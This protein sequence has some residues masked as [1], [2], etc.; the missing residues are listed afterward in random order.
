LN[1]LKPIQIEDGVFQIRGVG[2]KTTVVVGDGKPCMIDASGPGS[3]PMIEA[4]LNRMGLRP[5]DIDLIALTHYHPDHTGGL[6]KLVW[7]S[8]A[9]V[10]AHRL[11]ADMLARRRPF[12]SPF[13]NRFVASLMK[14]IL[15]PL[16][17][18]PV[19][20]DHYIEHGDMLPV[21]E[22]IRVVHTP[23][24]TSGSVCYYL[25]SRGMVIV[26]DALQYRFR[27]LSL[28]AA[29]VTMDMQ[30]AGESLKR[31]LELDFDTICFSHFPPL[32]HRAKETLADLVERTCQV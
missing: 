22:R 10:A 1:L 20:I 16:Y 15:Q 12:P 21:S 13:Q 2:S 18:K 28:P 27:K 30:Q 26:G 11:E 9:R 31:L 4:G 7:A 14:P 25:E 29:S 19:R 3:L 32:D 23:G 5:K 6:A 8:S 24:H 17:G